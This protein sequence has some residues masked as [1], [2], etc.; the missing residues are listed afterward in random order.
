MSQLIAEAR[1]LV[2]PDTTA[3]RA[4]L[5]KQLATAT[6]GVTVPVAVVPTTGSGS[7][8]AAAAQTTTALQQQAV[9]G[10]QAAKQNITAAQA[11]A[12]HA[13]QLSQ[14][15]RGAAASALSLTGLRG[16]T[17]AS[18]GPFLAGAVA[19]TGF[20]K[21]VQS[22]AQLET[23]LNTFRVTAGAT[24]EQMERIGEVSR[25]LGTD[26]TLPGV[27]AQSAADA[28]AQLSRAGLTVEDSVAG[29]RG[30]LQLATAAAIDNEQAVTLVANA[31]N[32][33][34]LTG[35]EAGR[36][37][38]LFA[39]ASKETQGDIVD[40]GLA[41]QQSAAAAA[42]AGLT[43]EDTIA[44]LTELGRAGL[45]GSDAG[46]SLRVAI[47][48]LI[49]PTKV[50]KEALEGLNIEIRDQ[51]GNLRPEAFAEIT[52]QLRQMTKAQ[53]DAT[54]ALIFGQDAF[55]AAAILGRAGARGFRETQQAVQET[56]AAAELAS[57]RTQGLA[58]AF[59]NLKN[60]GSGLAITIGD[61]AKG[62]ITGVVNVLASMTSSFNATL[63]AATSVFGSIRGDADE[64]VLSFEEL[65]EKINE[66]RT[67]G[68]TL[69]QT[70]EA[71]KSLGTA[72]AQANLDY[73]D[74]L[75]SIAAAQEEVDRFNDDDRPPGLTRNVEELTKKLEEQQ[76]AALT[77]RDAIEDYRGGL[78][79]AA[80]AAQGLTNRLDET[81]DR[82]AHPPEP[83]EVPRTGPRPIGPTAK[84]DAAAGVAQAEEDLR[85][86]ER[87]REKQLALAKKA[88]E[89]GT[90]KNVEDRTEL[91]EAVGQAE[92]NLAQVRTQ[93]AN[94]AEQARKKAAS[95][96]KSA[97]AAAA[98]A[99][100]DADTAFLAALTS[101]E[102]GA[103]NKQ[104]IASQSKRLQDD[105]ST[106]NA[107]QALY[108]QQIKQVR[109]RVKDAQVRTKTIDDLTT[110]LIKEQGN[111]TQLLKDLADRRQASKDAFA[112]NL[113]TRTS[114][115][116]ARFNE[117]TGAGK[118]AVLAAYD[119]E[120]ANQTARVARAKRLKKG[121]LDEILAL[122][123]LKKKRRE[124]AN[125]ADG[126][127]TTAFQLLTDAAQR[128]GFAGNLIGTAQPFAG[129][130]E[131]TADLSQFL[132][133]QSTTGTT[134]TGR[135]QQGNFSGFTGG[136]DRLV[137]ALN[138]NTAALN[139]GEAG[140]TVRRGRRPPVSGAIER[141]DRRWLDSKQAR[142]TIEG[143]GG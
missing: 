110:K 40:V 64:T 98:Q 1:V 51:Q 33:F 131:F 137:E 95:E 50:A 11:A 117:D 116:L 85:E 48:R 112:E 46:T 71:V 36:I 130:T 106:S 62:P 121:V 34:A 61:L 4:L 120:I 79:A 41:F 102:S 132:R 6:Q 88:F 111:E 44:L 45:R 89:N 118:S 63:G 97:A 30:T 141:N 73:L 65:V 125:S 113:A 60:Q 105:I 49:A 133:R 18:T 3:F 92:A 52:E 35:R 27:T 15:Q 100:K 123:E 21:A 80:D 32:A 68:E 138:A 90:R 2:T 29:V 17:L 104:E 87:I 10:A 55:R 19:V 77:A 16:A 14:L 22:S 119:K 54:L 134:A 78:A 122:E 101:T 13:K 142:D 128:F 140:P 72:A 70:A 99:Q 91:F 124:L 42:Q 39:A 31:L 57:A 75:Q 84:L 5:V 58:G 12:Q 109:K 67:N 28:L 114:I 59:E 96:A 56:G 136:V 82:M 20:A 127:G 69:G 24:A 8:A 25:E 93:I 66:I 126:Q 47:L 43:V 86:L 81:F 115:A 139:G 9:A 94:K 103:L 107:L 143:A 7:A 83:P 38:D 53:Q 37:A 26:L 108:Q 74:L 76:P 135:G 23:S 129:P